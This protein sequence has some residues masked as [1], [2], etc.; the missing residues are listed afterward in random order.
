MN[1]YPKQRLR[2][3]GQLRGGAPAH[4]VAVGDNDVAHR[5][6]P[7]TL[8]PH[9]GLV[10]GSWE[11]YRLAVQDDSVSKAR[12]FVMDLLGEWGVGEDIRDD[13]VLVVS[14]LVTNAIVH[15]ASVEVT[16][17]FGVTEDSMYVA[18]ADQGLDPVG[19]HVRTAPMSERGRGL[20]LVSALTE[21]WGV[22]L[23]DGKGRVV[24]AVFRT[25]RQPWDWCSRTVS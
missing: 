24:W 18:V 9:G 6:F 25:A 5:S 15:T 7:P 23:D 13:V 4:P 8:P 17:R 11:E 10:P 22:M 21:N 19:P 14:E 3:H 2:S 12:R 1:L 20:Q 16:C